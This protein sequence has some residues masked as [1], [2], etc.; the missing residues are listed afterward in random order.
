[1]VYTTALIMGTYVGGVA[2]GVGSM[3][4]D[5]FLGFPL[6]APG[7]L[8]IKATEGFIVGYLGNRKLSNLS[9]KAWRGI[10]AALAAAGAPILGD[11][12]PPDR[13]GDYQ[14]PPGF[15]VGPPVHPAFTPP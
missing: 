6:F 9:G 10:T 4:S 1:M 15:S 13:T 2:G 8:V 11:V 12:G 14:L 3:F 5:I 7:T